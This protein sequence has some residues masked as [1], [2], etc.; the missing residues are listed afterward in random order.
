V[1]VA[2]GMVPLALGTDTAG[3]VRVPAALCGIVGFK[4]TYDAISTAGVYPLAASLDHVGVFTRTVQDARFAY[5][6][7]VSQDNCTVRDHL[8]A[9]LRIGWIKSSASKRIVGLAEK[10]RLAKRFGEISPCSKT[11]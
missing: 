1:A 4:P 2:S 11:F 5:E 7:L 10:Q 9:A 3:S 6:V 8:S